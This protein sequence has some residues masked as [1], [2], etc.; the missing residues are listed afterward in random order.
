[1]RRPAALAALAAVLGLAALGGGPGPVGAQAPATVTVGLLGPFPFYWANYVA[2]DHGLFKAQGLTVE[3][4]LFTRPSEAVQALVGGSVNVAQVSADAFINAIDAGAPISIIGQMIGN[5]GFTVIV[6][7]EI[8][9]WSEVKD[10]KVGVSAP[11]DGAAVVFRMMAE[12][13]GLK[14]SDY[15]FIPVG[16]TPNRYAALKSRAV[17]V[18][19][20]AP[21][22]DFQ[23]MDEGYRLLGRSDALLPH[24][25]FIMVGAGTAWAKANR[26]SVVRYLSALDRATEWLYNPANRTAA[27][28]VLEKQM[29][30]M[31]R[32]YLERIHKSYFEEANGRIVTRGVRVELEG[33][34]VYGQKM[35]D[36]GILRGAVDPARWTDLSYR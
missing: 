11:K 23:A 15:A 34:R 33:L 32:P 30:K 6:Q 19:V 35:K 29:R 13:N 1:M 16:T 10:K 21:P 22:F 20:M 7:P 4:T 25:S 9:S 12:A 36:L 17:D 8:K 27:V 28:D 18:A 26:D 3:T 5:P 24:Y 2:A 31:G 14:E